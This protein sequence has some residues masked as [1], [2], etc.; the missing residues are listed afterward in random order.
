MN[1]WKG[2]VLKESD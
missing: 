1:F 2:L